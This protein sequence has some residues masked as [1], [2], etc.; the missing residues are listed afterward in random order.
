MLAADSSRVVHHVGGGAGAEPVPGQ[1]PPGRCWRACA[2]V[3]GARLRADD[4]ERRRCGRRAPGLWAA[5]AGAQPGSAQ[6]QGA[7]SSRFR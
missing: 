6:L 7:A 2:R 3:G 1:G 5:V 4:A